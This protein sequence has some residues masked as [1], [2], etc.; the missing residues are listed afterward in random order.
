MNIKTGVD[1]L[2]DIVSKKGVRICLDEYTEAQSAELWRQS[3][4]QWSFGYPEKV[5]V[6]FT[7][8]NQLLEVL[9]HEVGHVA[10]T[11]MYKY[12]KRICY[13]EQKASQWAL[14][15]LASYSYEDIEKA[16]ERYAQCLSNYKAGLNDAK[17]YPLKV[18]KHVCKQKT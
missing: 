3:S 12:K 15:F 8:Y 9:A 7:D 1:A 10:T 14:D 13:Y 6:Y 4:V 11:D 16:K 5:T 17:E 2:K 18:R